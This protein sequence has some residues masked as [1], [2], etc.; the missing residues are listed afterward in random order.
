MLFGLCLLII[1]IAQGCQTVEVSPVIAPTPTFP[2]PHHH[3]VDVNNNSLGPQNADGFKITE[4]SV[5]PD[6]SHEQA[7]L[8]QDGTLEAFTTCDQS[9]RI[10]FKELETGHIYEIQAPS[11]S[12][13]R[14]FSGPV[15]ITSDILI[16]D[17]W[18]QPHYGVHY[19]VDVRDKKLI[20]A[21]PFTDQIP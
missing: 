9:C 4:V 18:S 10:L 13:A 15:W 7:T 2:D 5:A 20:L 16:F 19:A 14:P 6:L 8:N 21:S 3:V 1:F 12:P 17:Q 11:F